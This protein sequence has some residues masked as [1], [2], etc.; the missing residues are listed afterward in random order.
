MSPAAA[1]GPSVVTDDDPPLPPG[2]DRPGFRRTTVRIEPGV[3]RPYRAADWV[4]CLVVIESGEVELEATSGVRHTC[5]G[6]D[7]LW[8]V[9][10]SLRCLVNRGDVPVV[11][12]TVRRR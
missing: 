1:T 9:G 10:L 12:T 4:D 3:C 6:G 2:A 8:L 5:R 11:I 7:V